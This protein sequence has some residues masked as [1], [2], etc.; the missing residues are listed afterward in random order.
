[1]RGLRRTEKFKQT[2]QV[3]RTERGS[4][5]ERPSWKQEAGSCESACDAKQ[6]SGERKLQEAEYRNRKE[7]T[8]TGRRSGEGREAKAE[9]L[10]RRN[11][12]Q[13]VPGRRERKERKAE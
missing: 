9:G 7:G 6:W 13:G 1:M 10:H 8:E 5:R 11:R 3:T 2:S 4:V 12:R